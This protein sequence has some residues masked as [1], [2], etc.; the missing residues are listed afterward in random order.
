MNVSR[1]NRLTRPFVL[2]PDELEKLCNSV[3]KSAKI[4]YLKV[5]CADKL[6]REFS[7]LP[8]L[9][10]YENPPNKAIEA[11]RIYAYSKDTTVWIRFYKDLVV[12]HI[13]VRC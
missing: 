4:K 1:D 10:E 5:E 8:E 13:K 3:E 2:T 9:L 6:D 11:I 7:S 12:A